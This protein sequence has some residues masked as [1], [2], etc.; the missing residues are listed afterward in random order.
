M[1]SFLTKIALL[2]PKNKRKKLPFVFGIS[3]LNSILD[4]IS[5]ALLAPYLLLLFDANESIKFLSDTFSIQVT[6]TH[7]IWSLLFLVFFYALKNFIQTRIIFKQ[8]KFV[9]SIASDI[10]EQLMK[11]YFSGSY[12]EQVQQDKGSIL[13]DF[14]QLPMLFGTYIL[15][16]LYYIISEA[17]IVFVFILLGFYFQPLA[18]LFSISFILLTAFIILKIR[19]KKVTS[20]NNEISQTY[21]ESLNQIMNAFNGF[22]QIK[23]AKSEQAFEDKFKRSNGKHN[24]Q[25]SL[26]SIYKQSNIR[27]FETFAIVVIAIIIL[28]VQ[29]NGM[30]FINMFILSFLISSIIKFIP[31]FNKIVNSVIDI[32]SNRYTVDILSGYNLY[33]NKENSSKTPHFLKSIRLQDVSFSYDKNTP[34]IDNLSMEISKGNFVAITGPSG[35]G[36]TTLLHLCTGVLAPTKGNV[37]I[38]SQIVENTAF[39]DFVSIV[40]Q[41]P[42]LFKGTLLENIVMKKST[43]ID[44]SFIFKLLEVFDLNQWFKG[45]EKG[46][47][48]ELMLDSKTISGGQKQRIAL[49][50][51]L[52]Q[53]PNLLLLDEATNQLD[54]ALEIKVLEYLK[55][56]VEKESLTIIAVSHN[57]ALLDVATIHLDLKNN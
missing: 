53:K 56:L 36:K 11:N 20:L 19:N 33:P 49:I 40:P 51:A 1:K 2:I 25:L 47:D 28:Y 10:S 4:F 57:K 22:L 24:E 29:V 38:D 6:T 18:T 52:Y 42:F 45:L 30:E 12:I 55:E 39:F 31:S 15:L 21:K 37:L 50:R 35:I 13:R 41:Q 23:S 44:T 48:T 54:T 9:Y 8:S 16:S 26:L 46:L 5:I 34:V 14:Q 3:L 17:F 43:D 7:I 32:R 27:Y